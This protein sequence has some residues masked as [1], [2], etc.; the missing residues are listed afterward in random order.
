MDHSTDRL[1][2]SLAHEI[3][4]GRDLRLFELGW[5]QGREAGLIAKVRA[6]RTPAAVEALLVGHEALCVAE[7]AAFKDARTTAHLRRHRRW[8]RCMGCGEIHDIAPGV[9]RC[10]E[11]GPA[12]V[13]VLRLRTSA[14]SA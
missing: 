8:A 2:E 3:A 7:A 10:A 5:M 9:D 11:C 6:A 14:V 13:P 12:D 1:R 4:D